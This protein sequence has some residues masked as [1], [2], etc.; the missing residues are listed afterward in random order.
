[1]PEGMRFFNRARRVCQ[2]EA[3]AE[4]HGEN[5]KWSAIGIVQPDAKQEDKPS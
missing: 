4:A 3:Y 2:L 5:L 1:M